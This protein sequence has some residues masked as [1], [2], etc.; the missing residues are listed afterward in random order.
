MPF[1]PEELQSIYQGFQP[2]PEALPD[3][4]TPFKRVK[5]ILNVPVN[6]L[7]NTLAPLRSLVADTSNESSVQ[8]FDPSQPTVPTFDVG[9]NKG[10]GD[11]IANN[12]I[13][14]MASW[15]VPYSAFGK[16]GKAIGGENRLGKILAEGIGQGAANALSAQR[17]DPNSTAFDGGIG[18]ASGILQ[19]ALPRYA[20]ALPLAAIAGAQYLHDG[21][22]IGAALNFGF[23]ML[24]GAAKAGGLAHIPLI[25]E[26]NNVI[27]DVPFTGHYQ[28][29]ENPLA[30]RSAAMEFGNAQQGDFHLASH[31]NDIEFATPASLIS[32]VETPAFRLN[33]FHEVEAPTQAQFESQSGLHLVNDQGIRINQHTVQPELDPLLTMQSQRGIQELPANRVLSKDEPIKFPV[34][35]EK[36]FSLWEQKE[37]DQSHFYSSNVK[38]VSATLKHPETKEIFEGPSHATA[39]EKMQKKY[40]DVEPKETIA[41][42]KTSNG[43][44]VGRKTAAKL[45]GQRKGLESEDIHLPSEQKAIETIGP[46]GEKKII[47]P[48]QEGP[49]I[50]STVAQNDKGELLSGD[51]WNTPHEQGPDSIVQSHLETGKATGTEQTG[52]IIQDKEGKIR[53]TFD[54]AEAMSI[55]KEAGQV[56]P[57]ESGKILNSQNLILSKAK[58]LKDIDELRNKVIEVESKTDKLISNIDKNLNSNELKTLSNEKGET[59]LQTL[60]LIATSGVAAGIAYHETKGDIGATIATGLLAA[61]LGITGIN[62]FKKFK[63]RVGEAK[64]DLSATKIPG[65]SLTEKLTNFARATMRTPAGEAV[66]GQGGVWANSVHK[67]EALLG[68]NGSDSLKHAKIHADGYAAARAQEVGDALQK[69]E[70]YIPNVSPAFVEAEQL[71]LRG[72][73]VNKVEVERIIAKGGYLSGDKIPTGK[74]ASDFSEKIIMLGDPKSTNIKG[75]EVKIWHVTNDVKQEWQQAQRDALDRAATSSTDRAYMS[76]PVKYREV[77]DNIMQMIHAGLPEGSRDANRLIGTTG[78]YMTRS[79]AVITDPAVYPTEEAI[80]NAMDRLG[81][82][83][84]VGFIQAKAQVTPSATHTQKVAYNGTDLY[85]TPSDANDFQFLHT[86]ESLRGDV[87][88][89]IKEIKQ[90]AAL[91]KIGS[92]PADSEQ[93]NASLFTGRKELDTV[94]QALLETKTLPLDMMH[95]TLA[96]LLPNAQ[97]SH[98]MQDAIKQVDKVTGMKLSM[99]NTEYNKLMQ[100]LRGVIEH[101]G[102]AP[103]DLERAKFQYNELRSYSRLPEN[104]RF[105]LAS[106][107]YV[108]RAL[109]GQIDSFDGTSFGFLDNA[110]GK[111][112]RSFNSFFKTTHLAL[113]PATVARQFIQA[114][115]MML[116]GNVRDIGMIR[117]GFEAYKNRSSGFGKWLT[118]HGVFSSSQVHGDFNHTINSVLDGSM[119]KTIWDKIKGG[120][121]RAHDLFSMPDDIVRAS[122]F[123]NEAKRVAAEMGV[124]LDSM[125]AEVGRRALEFTA[126]RAMN[127]SNLPQYVKIGR[128][129]PFVNVFLGYTHEI[130]RITKNL[131]VDAAKGDLQAGATLAGLTTLPFLAQKMAEDSLSPVD[132]A[133]WKQANNV[134]QDYS[135]SRFKIPMSR[136]KDGTFTYMDVTSWLPH[137]DFLQMAR[138]VINKDAANFVA[139]NP[140][141][142]TDK[143]PFFNIVAP[144][145][146]GEDVHTGREF[147]GMS[148]RVMNVASQL[149]PPLTPGIGSEWKKS[150]PEMLGGNLGQENIKTG[151]ENSIGG[152][153]MRNFTGADITQVN[154]DTAVATYIKAAQHQ[155]SNNK[156]YYYDVIKMKGA[157]KEA[158]DR[159]LAQLDEANKTVL[160]DLEYKLNLTSANK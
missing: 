66:G 51:K 80:T 34:E 69:V 99:T 45:I 112:L 87:R 39:F 57:N 59:Q 109:K 12:V 19:Q 79:H 117:T 6:V 63:G 72:Q 123:M 91:K 60:G 85:M 77:A 74:K 149:L 38:I 111:G 58:K 82:Q 23:N 141:F 101:P 15:M 29:F 146:T 47:T 151:R 88:D 95:D 67:A 107:T 158:Q 9:Q 140:L 26:I 92:M 28:S 139:V 105:S 126:R 50:I 138:S 98:F 156:Q 118:E 62:A 30:P 42:F 96:K 136:N 11:V 135:R 70:K 122:V 56:S 54:R 49:H 68:M 46:T 157:S 128:D 43:N 84:D 33:P 32:P 18:L 100:D 7:N 103:R 113:S 64:A 129:I 53:S 142:G 24:P 110:I 132:R 65:A 154:P 150:T 41:G 86:P 20:R 89:Y 81:I 90:N 94:T 37:I 124:P 5:Q 121:R 31:P 127:F 130:M 133:A 155:L 148:D 119:E 40:P 160:T 159:A 116:M 143:S 152:M 13:P 16:V 3:A 8:T 55:A 25:T 83:K 52:F 145:I 22:G 108:S 134:S 153:L 73:L 115:L 75:N 27:N 147:R 102:T 78:Q 10:W 48:T 1:T 61:G 114:P 2:Q 104:S 21:S 120:V 97:A 4:E 93:F 125:N 106:D 137:N 17:N 14:E 144:Q 36:Q 76:F 35:K 71:F 44:I 131:A